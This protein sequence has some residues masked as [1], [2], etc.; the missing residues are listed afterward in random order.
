MSEDAIL[1]VK[2]AQRLSVS[3]HTR[4]VAPEMTMSVGQSR[5]QNLYR[6]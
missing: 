3:S 4:G 5:I 6:H 1:K 2:L